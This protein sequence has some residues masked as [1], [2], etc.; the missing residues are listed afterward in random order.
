MVNSWWMALTAAQRFD[1]YF[2]ASSHP[3][4]TLRK[5]IDT[6]G[7]PR[8]IAIPTPV[9]RAMLEHPHT[10]ETFKTYRDEPALRISFGRF[11][12]EWRGRRRPGLIDVV[13]DVLVI[14]RGV[15]DITDVKSST[16]YIDGAKG[17][18]MLQNTIEMAR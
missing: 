11:L 15:I 3:L 4:E 14:P 6:A 17:S 5:A 2:S 8:R 12:F 7:R 13:C 18:Y 9:W 16:I 10:V 1:N